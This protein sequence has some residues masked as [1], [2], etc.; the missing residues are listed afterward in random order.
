[1]VIQRLLHNSVPISLL[2]MCLWISSA[3]SQPQALLVI[4]S[5]IGEPYETVRE[6]MLATLKKMGYTKASGF[7][8]EYY[9][10]GNYPGAAKNLWEHRI[11]KV[12]FDAIFLNGTLAVSAFKNIAWKMPGYSFVFAS[13]TDPVGLGVIDDYNQSPPANF[14][15]VAIPMLV[16]ERFGFVRKLMPNVKN[17]GMVYA[18]M[19]QSHS[20]RKWLET[21]A[22]QDD[23]QDIKFHFRQVDFIPSDGGHSRMAQLSARYILELDPIVDVFVSS[24]DQLGAQKPFSIQF[25]KIAKTPLIGLDQKGVVEG[26]GAVASIYPDRAEMGAQAAVMIDRVLK[27]ENIQKIF[28]ERPRKYG[29]VIDRSL[30]KKYGIKISPELE[31]EAE[32]IP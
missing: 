22:L 25:S 9:S 19:A 2:F 4:D 24:H 13:V 26:W 12:K 31:Q 28:P 29:I 15:G 6:S 17:I 23:W 7:T 32:I 20:Y 10:L 5:Q 27:G 14:T 21:L 8:F 30:A 18:D 11:K 1:M 16:D 3:L